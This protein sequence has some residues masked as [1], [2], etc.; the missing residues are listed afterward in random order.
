M[1]AVFIMI[2]VI[3]ILKVASNFSKK[4]KEKQNE[5][6]ILANQRYKNSMKIDREIL[7]TLKNI[8]NQLNN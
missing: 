5:M 8:E 3:F 7:D 6:N 4:N 1:M 2:S